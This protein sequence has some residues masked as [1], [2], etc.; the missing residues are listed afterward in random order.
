MPI[1]S[2]THIRRNS[3]RR[4]R[5]LRWLHGWI[6]PVLLVTLAVGAPSCLFKKKKAAAPEVVPQG[7]IRIVFLPANIAADNAEMRWMSLAVPVLMSKLAPLSTDIDPVPL[8]QSTPIAVENAGAARTINPELASYVASRMGARWAA[9]GDIAPSKNGI[10]LLIDFI[11]VNTA[12]YAFRYQK[13]VTSSA[14]ESNVWQALDRFVHYRVANPAVVKGS[15]AAMDAGLLRQ[16]AETMDSDYGWF[17]PPAPGKGDAIAAAVSRSDSQFARLIFSPTLYPV[18]GAPP[19][20]PQTSKPPPMIPPP[21]PEDQK[22]PDTSLVAPQSPAPTEQPAALPAQ[23]SAASAESAPETEVEVPPPKTFTLRA[24]RPLPADSATTGPAQSTGD[25]RGSPA[26][27]RAGPS[28]LTAAPANETEARS[29][30][31]PPRNSLQPSKSSGPKTSA[32]SSFRIQVS[33]ARNRKGAED[34]ARKFAGT[35]LTTD[36]EEADL[37]S[38]GIWYRLY[39][40]GF[41]SRDE[42]LKAARRLKAEGLIQDFLLVP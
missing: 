21:P 41:Q 15:K 4:G 23:A 37:G 11:P 12:S 31:T 9:M 32:P 22:P 29:S 7:P 19:P 24:S 36:I 1:Y 40:T 16:I 27:A 18:V 26:G 8:W 33:S 5:T 17:V 25:S 6:I 28:S 10:T 20:A 13:A 42:A 35:D 38:K 39:L 34:E 30:K 14:L 2:P 3:T